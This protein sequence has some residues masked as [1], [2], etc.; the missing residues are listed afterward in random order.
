LQDVALLLGLDDLRPKLVGN[1][2]DISMDA[3]L[4]VPAFS[5]LNGFIDLQLD[6][7]YLDIDNDA[8]EMYF[9]NMFSA[10][11]QLFFN[12]NGSGSAPGN[13]PAGTATRFDPNQGIDVP[14]VYIDP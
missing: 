7:G 13:C 9:S 10:L 1:L 14:C 3:Y 5:S 2:V 4:G 8:F 6:Q 11:A 12:G